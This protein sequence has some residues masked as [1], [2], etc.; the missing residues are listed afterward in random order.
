[1]SY[2]R[3]ERRALCALLD[4]TGP[5]APTLCEGWASRDLAAHLVLR[6]HRPDA[7]VGILGGPLARYTEHVQQRMTQ[8]VPY[9][10]LVETVRNGPPRLSVFG[11][12][13]V[14][15]RANLVEYF[16]HHEDV[17]RGADGWKPRD[18]EPGLAEQLWERL[19]MARFI[20]RK[21][22]VGIEL[23]RSDMDGADG[24]GKRHVLGR[25]SG[26][27]HRV[28]VKNGTPVV[29]VVG[30]PGELVMW[31]LGRTSAAEVRLEGAETAITALK[32]THWRL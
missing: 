27:R 31:A 15:E 7:G 21:A 3:D 26:L 29:T 9:P 2:S 4:E 32:S 25:K 17:R 16:V 24:A 23:A 19:G 11:I 28:T 20:L 12:P 14:D 1:M 30:H 8:H 22:P 6:E 10:R 18:I 5:D 13:G